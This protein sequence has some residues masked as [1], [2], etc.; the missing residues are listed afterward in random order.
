LYDV[1]PVAADKPHL[2]RHLQTLQRL[3]LIFQ[4]GPDPTYTFKNLLTQEAAYNSMLYSQRRQLHRLVAEWYERTFLDDAGAAHPRASHYATL[5]HHWRHADDPA[6]AI[7]YLEK[8]GQQALQDGA[9]QEAERLFEEGL[10]LDARSGVL[11]AG[12]YDRVPT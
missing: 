8:A 11:S 10:D 12:F 3:D 5:A 4:S 1:F 7:D 2:D 9:H 6:K